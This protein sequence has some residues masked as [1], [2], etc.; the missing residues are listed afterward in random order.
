L[1]SAGRRRIRRR[2]LLPHGPRRRRSPI[3]EAGLIDLSSCRVGRGRRR[4]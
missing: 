2:L 1:A 4:V 3:V